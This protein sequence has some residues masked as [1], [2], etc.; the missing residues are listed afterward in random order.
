MEKMVTFEVY[1]MDEESGV[2]R[3]RETGE[4]GVCRREAFSEQDPRK[5]AEMER[6]VS[7]ED[8]I[9]SYCFAT[10]PDQVIERVEQYRR[11][12]ATRVNICTHSFP[13]NIRYMGEKVLPHFTEK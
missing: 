6:E 5:I 9:N 8:I 13:E 4:A 12:G 10:S 3:M 2:K 7:D 11:V 1:L